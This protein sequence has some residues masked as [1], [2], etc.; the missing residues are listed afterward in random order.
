MRRSDGI[1]VAL[2][3]GEQDLLLEHAVL[4]EPLFSLV[5]D[6]PVDQGQV[7]L[8]LSAEELDDLLGSVAEAA[9]EAGSATPGAQLDALYER[10][11]AFEY[12]P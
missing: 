12:R 11:E 3:R 7:S 4:F 10:L 1:V 8:E 2:T 5:H 9:N 6:A